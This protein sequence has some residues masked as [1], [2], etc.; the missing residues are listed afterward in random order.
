MSASDTESSTP[1]SPLPAFR[2]S[3]LAMFLFV[4]AACI[5]LAWWVQPSQCVVE[6]LFSVSPRRPVLLDELAPQSRQDFELVAKTQL[7]YLKADFVLQ[8]ALRQPGIATLPVLAARDD[9][10]AWLMDRLEVEMKSDSQILAIRMRV[11]E[12]QADDLRNIVD[13]V[14]KAYQDEVVYAE[15][16]RSLVMRD[17]LAKSVT[18]LRSKIETR[19]RV[20]EETS[21]NSDG[22]TVDTK[23]SQIEIDVLIRIWRDMIAEL[24]RM[25]VNAQ[26]PAQIRMVQ[27]ATVTTE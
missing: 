7:A 26:A 13:A 22:D 4:T 19:M 20:Q 11:P 27:S 3:L 8:A 21:R 15:D 18:K 16:Q 12:D 10:V 6:A 14:C 9:Q 17:A 1:D 24:E 25:D 23:L 2:F 5:L